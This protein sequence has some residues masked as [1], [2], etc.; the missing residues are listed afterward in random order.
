MRLKKDALH[1]LSKEEIAAFAPEEGDYILVT[2]LG[3]GSSVKVAEKYITPRIKEKINGLFDEG[4]KVVALLCT[5]EFRVL[6]LKVF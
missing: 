1:N 2:R 4:I 6:L 5:G 3:D